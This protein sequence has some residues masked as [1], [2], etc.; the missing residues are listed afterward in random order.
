MKSIVFVFSLAVSLHAFAQKNCDYRI[1]TA[2]ILL[3]KNLDAFLVKIK[4]KTFSV[5]YDKKDIPSFIKKQLDCWT[6][7]FSIANPKE[8]F[9]VTDFYDKKLPDRQLLFLALNNE[10]LIMTYI[11]GGR[12]K[13]T[14]ILFVKF[15]NNK[16]LDLW[17]GVCDQDLKSK[18]EILDY[19]KTHRHKSFGLNFKWIYF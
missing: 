8:P 15:Q 17:T 11:R 9:N 6:Q 1:D 4:N 13:Q 14:H 3:N 12:A 7:N 5:S 10:L 18:N 19:I 16:I 2:K